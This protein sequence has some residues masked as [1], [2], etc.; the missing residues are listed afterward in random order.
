MR[1]SIPPVLTVS[2]SRPLP[3]FSIAKRIGKS[4]TAILGELADLREL[5][6][7]C[8]YDG[9]TCKHIICNARLDGKYKWLFLAQ[10]PHLYSKYEEDIC[11]DPS[12]L[13]IR[14]KGRVKP[15][16]FDTMSGDVREN[17]L[18]AVFKKHL[19]TVPFGV[20]MYTSNR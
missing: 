1:T 20:I 11:E 13:F 16:I 6:A 10:L 7:I 5:E 4:E 8:T 12:P 9:T 2:P 18:G 14:L 17:T 3:L 15:V 19:T